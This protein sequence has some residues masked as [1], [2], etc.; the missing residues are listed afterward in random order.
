VKRQNSNCHIFFAA[1]IEMDPFDKHLNES[2]FTAAEDRQSCDVKALLA[3]AKSGNLF[4]AAEIAAGAAIVIEVQ[5]A[6]E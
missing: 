4:A 6:R 1:T 2:S 3:A 5:R